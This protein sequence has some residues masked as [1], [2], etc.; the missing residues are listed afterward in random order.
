MCTSLEELR[1]L[2]S[3]TED[4]LDDLESTKKRLGR[5]Y[6]RKEAV[7]D[8]HSTL[9]RL[10]NELSPWE[11]KLIKAYQRNRLRLKKEFDDF[12]K[13]PDYNNFV[14]EECVSSSSDDDDEE[15]EDEERELMKEMCSEEEDLDH[16][17]P[18]GLWRGASTRELGME[19]PAE[20]HL[21]HSLGGSEKDVDELPRAQTVSLSLTSA[22][23]RQSG[24][25][26]SPATQSGDSALVS[27]TSTALRPASG[28]PKGYTPIPT[29]LAKSVGNKVTL[30]K[31]PAGFPSGSSGDG[32]GRAPSL[33]PPAPTVGDTI[34][35]KAQSP[36]S[37]LQQEPGQSRTTA[38]LPKSTQTKP[39]QSVPKSPIQVVYKVPEG[40]GHLVKKDSSGPIKFSVHPV[41]DHHTGDKVMPQVVILPSN[42]LLHS[43]EAKAAPVSQQQSGGLQEA[44]STPLRLSTDVPGFSIPENRIPVQQVAP[45]RDTRTVSAPPSVP[46]CLPQGTISTAAGVKGAPAC[47]VPVTKPAGLPSSPPPVATLS[48]A[49]STEPVK[50]ADPKQEL[51]T[52]CIRDSQSILVTTR[53]GNTGI[54]KVQTSSDQSGFGSFPSCPVITISPQF[55]AFLVSKTS[56]TLP[57]PAPSQ[58]PPSSVPPVPSL[59]STHSQQQPASVF[60][61]RSTVSVPFPTAVA[62]TIPRTDPGSLT[63]GADAVSQG[64]LTS[65]RPQMAQ[66]APTAAAGCQVPAPVFNAAAPALSGANL[67][68]LPLQEFVSKMGLKRAS[69]DEGSQVPKF[70]LVT[71]SSSSASN[72]A[73]PKGS[74]TK[75]APSSRVMIISQPTAESTP[76]SFT[77]SFPKQSVVTALSGPATATSASSHPLKMAASAGSVPSEAMSITPPSGF[78]IQLSGKTTTIGQSIGA[79]SLSPSKGKPVSGCTGPVPVPSLNPCTH[80]PL[81]LGPHGPLA[82]SSPLRAVPSLATLPQATCSA[83]PALPG[84]NAT[85]TAPSIPAAAAP[86]LV[87][88]A[89]DSSSTQTSTPAPGSQHSFVGGETLTAVASSP[90]VACNKVQAPPPPA[91]ASCSPFST[92]TSGTVQQRLLINTSTP[93]AAGTQ[94]LLNNA[95]F[96]VPPQGLGPG[97]H[98]LI[99]SSPAPPQVPAASAA[100][101]GASAPPPG[102]GNPPPSAPGPPQP[103]AVPAVTPPF[104][105]PL[106]LS[107]APHGTAGQLTGFGSPLVPMNTTVASALPRFPAVQAASVSSPAVD[108]LTLVSPPP[109]LDSLPALVTPAAPSAAAFSSTRAA[110]RSP[111]GPS[112]VPATGAPA[113]PRLAGPL[114]SLAVLSGPPPPAAADR[115]AL[116]RSVSK[117]QVVALTALGQGLQPQK[118][119][120]GVST[121]STAA[122][123]HV[124]LGNASIRTQTAVMQTV[125]SGPRTQVLPT[126]AVPPIISTAS[127]IQ[128]L[129]VATVPPIGSSDSTV[130]TSPV[131]TAPSFNSTVAPGQP[132]ASLKTS[133][134]FN[135]P[136][137]GKLSPGVHANMASRLLV[138]PDG[139]VLSVVQSPGPSATPLEALQISSNG[140]AAALQT[141]DSSLQPVQ[142]DTE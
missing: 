34:P 120:V 1:D 96:V 21:T 60:K 99:I 86:A 79:L 49:L 68:P 133:S 116:H 20:N 130:E 66:L 19:L 24:A 83:V 127:R 131:G 52:V 81:Q 41:V 50:A 107:A 89:A 7:K 117:Q 106:L 129:P 85:N 115:A 139:A 78:Q 104:V 2:I 118:M 57:P 44:V 97:S 109:K 92:S 91:S 51:K 61:P 128:T 64:P 16:L 90:Q 141:R 25:E 101:S 102:A 75:S 98:V 35:S 47:S 69:T 62:G 119:A 5:W 53:G 76:P 132:V 70:I 113:F 54:V 135:S 6:Y 22:D 3:K 30:M 36:P 121:P 33:P 74:P 88:P 111:A 142:A 48:S 108:S 138:S 137:C 10:L 94:I 43:A 126:V 112:A 15:E 32:H 114:S 59:S 77:G 125:L 58:P 134:S 12:K 80:C 39:T 82:T 140:A 56:Q 18:R 103:P 84:G 136:W 122:L 55:K 27:H 73:L 72:M 37:D 124:G 63:H 31:R 4:E 26:M 110:I 29:L 67:P 23:S 38:A 93:L 95:C 87:Q 9:I 46:P 71:P 65:A 45:L 28:L 17:V 123:L 40:L 42:L 11:P 105:A 8:L 13:H 100:S 14:R